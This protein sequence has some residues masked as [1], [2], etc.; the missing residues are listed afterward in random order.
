MADLPLAYAFSA[1]M[2]ATVNP[3]GF[4][5]LPAYVSYQL[6]AREAGYE[7][8]PLIYRAL[9]AL[10]LGLVVTGGFV[11][12]FS[13]VGAVVALGGRAIVGAVPWAALVIGAVLV[14]LGLGAL[15]GRSPHLAALSRVQ[16]PSGAGWRGVFLFGV[17]YAVASLSCTLPIFLV[18][19]GSA[20]AAGGAVPALLMFLAYGLGMGAVMIAVTLGAALF[21]GAVARALRRVVPYVERASAVLL[22]GAGGYIVYYWLDAL[23]WI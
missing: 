6:G 13:A 17:A 14:L 8:R 21:K 15:V 7:A 22:I 10:A 2:V 4:A 12:L 3:C 23:R 19:V 9:R 11:L 20:L 18:V 1:G 5:M 16:L